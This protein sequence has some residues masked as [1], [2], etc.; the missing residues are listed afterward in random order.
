MYL[1]GALVAFHGQNTLTLLNM[2]RSF[3][4]PNRACAAYSSARF[5]RNHDR[6]AISMI[7]SKRP[8]SF[9]DSLSLQHPPWIPDSRCVFLK[10]CFRN[11]GYRFHIRHPERRRFRPAPLSMAAAS[12]YDASRLPP[13]S[14]MIPAGKHVIIKPT[15]GDR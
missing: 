12:P 7:F 3:R 1:L 15:C 9:Q 2:M 4:F 10:G 14:S 11:T 5:L 6:Q 13:G 8:P